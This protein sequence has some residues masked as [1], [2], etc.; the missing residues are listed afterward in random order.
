MPRA[1]ALDRLIGDVLPSFRSAADVQAFEATAR[2]EDRIAAQST[3]EAVQRG[4]AIA[5]QAPALQFIASAESLEPAVTLSH[6]QFLARVTQSGNLFHAH[7]VGPQDVVSFLL[8]LLPQYYFG[9]LGAQVAGIANP[10][11]PLLS[12]HQLAEILRAAR[13]KVLVIGGAA[14][15]AKG[16]HDFDA[17]L[18]KH[19]ADRV[20]SGRTIRAD[21]IAGY[22]HTGGTT[23]TPKLV[24]HTHANQVYQAWGLRLTLPMGGHNLL[25]GLPLFHVGGSLTQGL[26]TLAGGGCIVALTPSGWRDAGMVRNAWKLVERYRPAVFGG[27]PTVLAAALSVPVDGA[28]ISSVRVAS[29]GGSAIPVAVGKAYAELIHGPVLEVY[30]MTETASVHTMSYPE[31]PLRLGS[32]GEPLP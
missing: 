29:G 30:G 21:D 10:V 9:L 11:N 22:F 32:V 8:P 2:Y 16:V 12:P 28:D 26:A 1:H 3:Y 31:R 24:R 4:A 6:A 17:E 15:P 25:C 18:A 5:P 14:D 19:P 7:G 13:T 20:V 27:V 23:G